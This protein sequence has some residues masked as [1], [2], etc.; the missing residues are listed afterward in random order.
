MSHKIK[1]YL[2]HGYD[3]NKTIIGLKYKTRYIFV[4]FYCDENKTIIGLKFHQ[5]NLGMD[6][7]GDEN[8]TIIGLKCDTYYYDDH[9][10]N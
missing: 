3:E 1:D 5:Y 10:D 7:S 8:K 4:L 6:Y 9:E 2:Y